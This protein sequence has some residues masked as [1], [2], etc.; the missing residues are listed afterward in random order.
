MILKIRQ[1][2]QKTSS[3]IINIALSTTHTIGIHNTFNGI[4][5]LESSGLIIES[6][7]SLNLHNIIKWKHIVKCSQY[8]QSSIPTLEY[9][10]TIGK[11]SA[12]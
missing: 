8:S 6:N 7:T 9:K 5:S 2:L 10:Y 3:V 11:L 12:C 1:G 4:K